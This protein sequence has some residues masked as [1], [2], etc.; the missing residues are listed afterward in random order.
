[1]KHNPEIPAGEGEYTSLADLSSQHLTDSTHTNT[2]P[3]TYQ[4]NNNDTDS[5]QSHNNLESFHLFNT[6]HS[7]LVLKSLFHKYSFSSL[8]HSFHSLFTSPKDIKT[9]TRYKDISLFAILNICFLICVYTPFAIYS[10]DMSQFDAKDSLKTLCILCGFFIFFA[11][12]L[13]YITSFLYR[14]RFLKLATWSWSI[15][16]VIGIIDTFIFT[17]D[18]G[19]M[20]N[21]I[22]QNP[23]FV[24]SDFRKSKI[25]HAIFTFILSVVIVAIV[26]KYLKSIFQILFITIFLSSVVYGYKILHTQGDALIQI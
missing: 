12:V 1:M 17:G 2:S 20:D 16:L 15:L 9:Y 26:F 25:P 19:V 5:S 14:S 7:S 11:L 6:S 24:D 3:K 8:W 13:V 18:Y 22:L 10:S 4:I 21:F 23:T